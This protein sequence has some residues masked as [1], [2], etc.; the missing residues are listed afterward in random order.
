M[1]FPCT[2]TLQSMDNVICFKSALKKKNLFVKDDKHCTA[3]TKT[4]HLFSPQVLTVFYSFS[5]FLFLIKTSSKK[6]KIFFFCLP[7]WEYKNY[8]IDYKK[9]D[10]CGTNLVFDWIADCET[11][12]INGVFL[13]QVYFCLKVK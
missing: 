11:G 12:E 3:K 10:F 13:K 9:S 5:L 8:I 7:I 1:Q 6:K 2:H 4:D